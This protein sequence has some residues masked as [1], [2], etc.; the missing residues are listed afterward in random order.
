MAYNQVKDHVEVIDLGEFML[1]NKKG[2]N[3]IKY[4]SKCKA[5]Q[6]IG[7]MRSCYGQF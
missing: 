4:N 3:D 7:G 5:V 1:K 6:G 2:V